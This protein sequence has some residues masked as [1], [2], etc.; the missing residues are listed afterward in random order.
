M[1]EADSIVPLRSSSYEATNV[2]FGFLHTIRPDRAEILRMKFSRILERSYNTQRVDL[3]SQ[4]GPAQKARDLV[5]G[6]LGRRVDGVDLIYPRRSCTLDQRPMLF[7]SRC[8]S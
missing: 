1:S 8:K 3:V 6:E 7:G 2:S 4:E 5:G